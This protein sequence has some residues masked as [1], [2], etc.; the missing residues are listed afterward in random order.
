MKFRP[1]D[2]ETLRR[3]R[4]AY[5]EQRRNR[6]ELQELRTQA[7]VVPVQVSLPVDAA[8]VSQR[9]QVSQVTTGV[10]VMGGRNEQAQNRQNRRIAAVTTTRHVKSSTLLT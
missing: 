3:E 7:S 6:A 8:S 10:S 2:K 1:E 9:S 5:N 4:A